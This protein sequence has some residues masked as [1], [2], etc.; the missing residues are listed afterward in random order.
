MTGEF[1]FALLNPAIASVFTLTFL[2][3]WGAK[4]NQAYLLLLGLAFLCCGLA[5]A[6]HD[7][8]QPWEGPGLRIA[9]NLLFVLAAGALCVSA[10]VRVRAPIPVATLAG[11][12]ALGA[13]LFCWFLLV[14]P[15][16]EGRIYTANATLAVFG[17]A[18]IWQLVRAKPASPVDWLFVALGGAL[19]VLSMAR[20][21]AT[22]A[23]AIDTNP[24]G[25]LQ[26]SDYWATVQAS[27]P[28][29]AATT[30]LAFFAGWANRAVGDAR[31]EADRDYLT[32]LLNRRGFD[33]SVGRAMGLRP[34]GHPPSAVMLVDIDNFK[35]VNDRFGHLTGDQV[36]AAAGKVLAVHGQTELVGRT[37][38]EEFTLFYRQS[39]RSDLLAAAEALR[40]EFSRITV[41]GLPPQFP[42]SISIGI[43]ARH[44][45]EPLSEM[46][47]SADRALYQAKTSGKDKAVMAPPPLKSVALG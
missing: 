24:G 39:R 30:A 29:L 20:P 23:R 46:M 38:G 5:F 45:S 41:A 13:M 4:R 26:A 17:L 31:A 1:I 16:T 33:T 6:A 18:T 47:A 14:E 15:S 11:T 25:P 36:I 28:L 43:H 40:L 37:G 10:L 9:V 32:G 34:E 19:S 42:L 12:F 7:F 44:Q 27:T 2:L 21:I 22:L 35:Q 8:L 3:M